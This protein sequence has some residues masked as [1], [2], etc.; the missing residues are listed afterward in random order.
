MIFLK[1]K[2]EKIINEKDQEEEDETTIEDKEEEKEEKD[3]GLGD[4]EF[5]EQ[6]SSLANDN[7]E[8]KSTNVRGIKRVKVS[9]D[10]S[11]KLIDRVGIILQIFAQRTKS[12]ISQYQVVLAYLKLARSMIKREGDSFKQVQSVHHID[13]LNMIDTSEKSLEI[14][15][16]KGRRVRGVLGGD[17][18]TELQIQKQEIDLYENRIK[19]KL[20][21]L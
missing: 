18:Q 8:E 1:K 20:D 12:P 13:I 11:L 5:M 2:W 14:V 6:L 16:S 4:E 10:R 17:G 9:K 21:K 15:S 19:K 3:K 7:E